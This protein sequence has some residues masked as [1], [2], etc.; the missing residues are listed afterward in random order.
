MPDKVRNM[1]VIRVDDP[2]K[3]RRRRRQNVGDPVN[4]NEAP[5]EV[6]ERRIPA[7]A[8]NTALKAAGG[9]RSRLVFEPDGSVWVKNHPR[10]A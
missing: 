6:A 3:I 7:A 4:P 9:D 1:A 5:R 2:A 10:P 8:L